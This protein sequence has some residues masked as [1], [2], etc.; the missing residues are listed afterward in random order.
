MSLTE[1]ENA[2][3]WDFPKPAAAGNP[4]SDISTFRSA[5][6]EWFEAT[7]E[8]YPWRR[9]EDPYAILVSELML[10]QTQIA[11]VLSRGYFEN[12]LTKFPNVETLTAAREDEILKAWEGLGYYRR[13]RNLQRAAAA[14]VEEFGGEFPK[15]YEE[16]RSLPGVGDYTAG[17]VVSF[18]YDQPASMVDANVARVLARL[19]DFGELIDATAGRKQ[20]A[21]W[22][23]QLVDPINARSFNSGLME[24]GQRY[25]TPRKPDCKPCPVAEFCVC[26]DPRQLP[27]KKA[28]AKIEAIEEH[29]LFIRDGAKIW[30][31]Q[32][33]KGGRREGLW[34]LPEIERKQIKKRTQLFKTKYSITKY[35]VTLN[36]F[37]GTPKEASGSKSFDVEELA[38]IAMASPYRKAV[39]KLLA[40]EAEGDLQFNHAQQ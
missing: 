25:C 39:E 31:S 37:A 14:V 16:I 33:A 15:T 1:D 26:Q 35:R 28:G 32:A 17:A 18:A 12:W 21:E 4:L 3:N 8:D 13:A 19:F 38:D 29:A 2:S 34:K 40:L 7:G 24:L 10:Q 9:T 22:S 30:L 6:V 36:V 20:L 5:I 27:N 23:G 11:T